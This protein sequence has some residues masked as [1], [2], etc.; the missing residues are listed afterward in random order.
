[1]EVSGSGGE[2]KNSQTLPGLKPRIIQLVALLYASEL[3]RL[4]HDINESEVFH[5][6]Q[7]IDIL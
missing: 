6:P 7:S 1:M 3:Y 5:K 2:E 4:L